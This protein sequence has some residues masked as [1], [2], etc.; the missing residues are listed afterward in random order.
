M[1]PVDLSKFTAPLYLF[2]KAP[3]GTVQPR[4]FCGSSFI[5]TGGLLVTCWHCIEDYPANEDEWYGVV[6]GDGR[7]TAYR[8]IAVTEL[9]RDPSGVDLATA[10]VDVADSPLTLAHNCDG[11]A[12][13]VGCFGYPGTVGRLPEGSVTG[14]MR[15]LQESRWLEG[16]VTRAFL[17]ELP[18]GGTA[19]RA[20]EIDM[21]CPGG[22]SGAP[23][24]LRGQFP[25]PIVVGVV[26]GINTVPAESPER[27]SLLPPNLV[28]AAAHYLD[29]VQNLRG[30]VLASQTLYEYLLGHGRISVMIST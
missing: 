10:H 12:Q 20:W 3:D 24:F 13:D 7:T 1:A 11:I 23:V 18:G 19:R 9:S 25:A 27:G 28:F 26:Y 5:F 16:Y 14:Q 29:V 6:Y 8:A 2:G 22:L 21:P 15:F 17:H 30:D 4:R